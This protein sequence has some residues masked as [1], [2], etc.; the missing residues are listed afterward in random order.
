MNPDIIDDDDG[1][2]HW[3]DDDHWSAE[4]SEE[5]VE[6][7]IEPVDPNFIPTETDRYYTKFFDKLEE[8]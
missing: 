6:P 4:E 8:H 7:P 5:D 1:W 3:S 2:N